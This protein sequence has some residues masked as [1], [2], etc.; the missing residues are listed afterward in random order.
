[1][2]RRLTWPLVLAQLLCAAAAWGDITSASLEIQGAGLRVETVSV[3]TGVDIPTT[4]QTSFGNR[5]NDDSPAVPGL[6]AV[7]DL[8]GPGIDVP[9]QLTATP[10]YRFH[11]PGLPRL[12]DYYLQNIRLMNGNEVI[13]PATPSLAKITVADLLQTSLA[14]RQLTPEQIRE[15]GI[16][17]DARNYD[18]YEYTFTFLVNGETVEVPFPVI[19]DPRTH[20]VTPVKEEK[21]YGLPPAQKNVQPPRWTP[22]EVIPFE[23]P[24]L[25][26]EGLPDPG[27]QP[28]E[29]NVRPNRP[30]IPAALVIPNSLAVLHQFFAVMLTVTNGA[31]TG[32]TARLED[33]G[34]TMKIK[35]PTALRTVKSTP[36]V[37]FGQA[38][39]VVDPNTGVT[40]LLAQGKGE[41]EWT[42]EGLK[43]GTHTVEVDIRATLREQGQEDVQLRATPSASVIIHDPRFNITFSHPDT[44]RRGLDYSTFAFI[45]NMSP[46]TQTIRVADALPQCGAELTVNVCRVAGGPPP[47]DMTIPAGEMRVVEYRLRAGETGQVFATAGSL[48]GDAITAAVQLHMGISASG[49]PLSPATLVLPYYAQFLHEDLV[50]DY[51][52]L[53]GLGYSLAT[54]PVNQT[55]ARFPRV[56]KTDVFY[57]ANDIARAG[58][59]VFIGHTSADT[60]RDA[61]N[62]LLL[63][64]LGNSIELR[65]WDE[66][67]R[68]EDAG[69]RAGAAVIR[70]LREA[71]IANQTSIG[72]AFD[73]FANDTS[74]RD[75]FVVALAH[76]P[77]G[78]TR[79]VSIALRGA[80]GR[81][82]S[83]ANEEA[84]GWTRDLA[85]ADVS[86]FDAFDRMGEL[87]V[88]GRWTEDLELIIT[89]ATGG[90]VQVELLFPGTTDGA[91]MR[92]HIE[93]NTAANTPLRVPLTRGATSLN[94]LL[95]NGGFA[96]TATASQLGPAALTILGA[97]QD[98]HLDKEG[99][100][101]S[102]LFS[103]PVTVAE[104]TDL[105]TRFAG[106]IDFNRDGIVFNDARPIFAAALQGDG[107]VANLSFDHVLSTNASYKITVSPFIDP[108]G[109]ASVPFSTP[110]VPK[111]DMDRPAGILY[112]RFLTGNN[113]PIAGAE[114]KFFTG[115]FVGCVGEGRTQIELGIACNPFAEAPQ[116]ARTRHD[117]SFL[118][119]YVPR[120]PVADPG[121]TGAYKAVGVTA[122]GKAT[123]VE[124]SVR[125]PGR[126]HIVNLQLL[127]RG[128]AE[129]TV[130]YDN[131]E[132]ARG[133]RVHVSSTM[134]NV[135][136][137]AITDNDGFFR[138]DDLA[139]GPITLGAQDDAG[140]V[141]FASGE[142]ATPGQVVVKE[143]VIFRKPFP[144][145]GTVYGKVTRSDN[146]APVFGARV[147]VYS[148]GYGFAEATTDS[149]GK[150][151]FAKVPSGFVT[152]LAAE[153]S[154]S[155]ENAAADFDLKADETKEMN[156]TISVTPNDMPLVRVTGRVLRENPLF[157]GDP[158]KY[159]RVPG[160]V[161]NLAILTTTAN[162]NG[163]FTF[164]GVPLIAGDQGSPKTIRAYDPSTK[165]I[166]TIGVP[167]LSETQP[168]DVT[169]FIPANSY[170]GG[171]IRVR[172]V[173]AAGVAVDGFRVIEPG[174]PP[175]N[176]TR[177]GAGLY[178]YRDAPI[179]HLVEVVAVDGPAAYG[180]QV[181]KG[182]IRL[183]FPGQT[184]TLI[185]RLPGQGTVRTKLRSDF[186]LIGDVALTFSVWDENEQTMMPFTITRS[187]SENGVAGFATFTAVP[188]LQQ[189]TV[190]SGHPVY[191]YA[192]QRGTLAYDGDVTIHTLQ[193]NKLATVRGT[194]YAID[195]ITPIANA[196]VRLTDGRRD[197]GIVHTQPDGTFVFH[198]VPA[199]VNFNVRAD[200]T[201]SGIY[202][203][204]IAF[205][206]TP[207][208]G[209]PAPEMSIILRRRGSVEGKVVYADYK[210]YDAENPANRVADDTPNDYSDNAPVPLAKLW[211]R[212][213]D[214]PERSF[215]SGA[216]P[217]TADVGGRFAVSNVF[218]GS[219]R[220]S[221]WSAENPDLRG[222]WTGLLNDEG[223]TLT[224]VYIAIGGGGTGSLQ[225]KVVDPNQQYLPIANAEVRLYR[226]GL[227]DLATTDDAGLV[228]F[229]Q[230]PVGNYGADAYSKSLGKS[231]AGTGFTIARDQLTEIRI[232]LEF[233]GKVDGRLT[234][235]MVTPAR[236]LPGV[237]VKLTASSFY[238]LATT[239][240]HGL[241]YF[242]G[243]REGSFNLEAKDTES[244]R[245]ASGQ[246]SVTPA[247]RRPF[248]ELELERTESLHVA[249]YLPNDTGGNSGT[250]A[251][252]FEVD[253]VQRCG[254]VCDYHRTLQGNPLVFPNLFLE[255][256]YNGTERYYVALKEIGGAGRTLS[257]D[258]V[259]PKG[260]AADPL[261]VVYPAFGGLEITVMQSGAL[262]QGARV[263]M[264]QGGE[265]RTVYTNA[266]GKAAGSGFQ[267]GNVSVQARSLDGDFTGSATVTIE[268]TSQ[269]A[270]RTIELG[271]YAGVSGFVEAEAGGASVGTRV[272][273]TFAGSTLEMLTDSNGGYLFQGI[274]TTAGG[275]PVS[276]SYVGPDGVTVG[277]RQSTS[278]NNDWSSRVRVLAPVKL[279]ATPPQLLTIAPADGSQNVSPDAPVTFVFSEQLDAAGLTGQNLQL[280]AADGSGQVT[281]TITSALQP[282]KTFAVTLRP[283]LQAGE[284]FPLKSNTLYR[285][286]VQAALGDLTGHRLPAPR[287]STFTT[288][289]YAEPRVVKL[290]PNNTA[291]LPAQ[292]TLQFHFN[293]PVDP[294]TPVFK[295]YKLSAAGAG[296]AVVA[297]KSGRA[298]VD[299]AGGLFLAF[300]PDQEIEPES[301]YRAV[302]TGV[303]DL[304]GNQ[305][306][307]QTYHYFSFDQRK[308][309]LRLI[310]PVPDGTSL[311]SGVQYTLNVDPRSDSLDGPVATDVA[312]VEYV[313]V[314]GATETFLT[315]VTAAPFAYRFSAPEAPEAGISYTIRA[316]ATDA[317]G[318]TGPP[319]TI[320]W[321]VK[322]NA[323][324]KN[325]GL[326][327]SS[328]SAYPGATITAD[329]TFEDEGILAPVQVVAR[330]PK[331][332]GTEYVQSKTAEAR[333]N[334]VGDPWPPVALTF[335]LPLTLTSGTTTEFTAT[336]TDV[337]GLSASATGSVSILADAIK[338][339]IVS[340]TPAP[341]KTYTL[342][343][344]YNVAAVVSD[345]ETGVSEVQFVIDGTQHRV[346]AASSTSGPG[347]GTRTFTS[348]QIT[349][350]AR[351]VDTRI[352]IIFRAIDYHGNI[353]TKTF[354]VVYIGVNDPTAPKGTW[355]C[356][357]DRAVIPASQTA[358]GLSLKVRAQDDVSVTAVK[359]RIPGLAEPV[360]ASRIGTSDDFE[361]L[362]TFDTPA[363]GSDFTIAAIISDAD[364]THTIELPIAIDVVAFDR[365]IEATEAVDA[366]TV[367]NYAGKSLLV[368][369]P[370][371]LVINVPLAVPNLAVTVGGRIET[372]GSTTARERKLDLTVTDRL[373]IDCTSTADVTAKGYLGGWGVNPDGTNTRSDS[374]IGRTT[375]NVTTGGAAKAGASHGGIATALSG[376]ATNAVYGSI[377]DPFELGSGG[378]GHPTDAN[379]AGGTGGGAL[380]LRTSN[381][382]D[383]VARIVVAG[384]IR[385]D[386]GSGRHG[387][388]GGSIRL[389]A[390]QIIFGPLAQV[391]ANGARGQNGCGNG[392]DQ[393]LGGS[394]GRIA[395]TA[396][397]RLELAAPFA[398][399]RAFG[400]AVGSG[401]SLLGAG[402]GT[403]YIRRPGQTEGEL[404]VAQSDSAA[405]VS[406]TRS[407]PL[408]NVAFD[409]ITLGPWALVRMDGTYSVG[410]VIDDP[411]K[412]VKDA[413]AIVVARNA[414]PAISGTTTPATGAQLIRNTPLDLLLD[415]TA[416]GGLVTA[417]SDFSAAPP[418]RVS[419]FGYQGSI[420]DHRVTW[421]VPPDAPLGPATLKVKVADRADRTLETTVA[422]FTVIDNLA[423]VI[424][425]YTAL[426]AS[427]YPGGTVT[428]SLSAH[429]DVSVTKI[430]ATA[431]IGASA[432][433][434]Q[435]R[436]PNAK[437]VTNET[438]TFTIPVDTPGGTPMTVEASVEDAFPG[439]V[440][441]KQTANITILSDTVGPQVTI[442][443]PAEAHVFDE[444]VQTF[445]INVTATDGEV[446]VRTVTARVG[447]GSVVTLTGNAAA[448]TWTGTLGIP[449]VDGEE[450]VPFT[451]TV[452]ATDYAG[453]ATP[454]TGTIRV[455]PTNDPN[456]PAVSWKCGRVTRVAAGVPVK[457]RVEAI[458]AN[459]Q[460]PVQ[461]VEF[462]IDSN[463]PLVATSIGSNLY[464]AT[465][466]VPAGAATYSVRA[467]GT[468][469]GGAERSFTHT[470]T[471]V[472]ADHVFSASTTIAAAD[473]SY[474]NEVIAVTAGTLTIAGAHT[475]ADLFVLGTA[476][477]THPAGDASL[478]ITTG[479]LFIACDASFDVTSRGYGSGGTYP[480]ATAAAS[481]AG[482]SHIGLGNAHEGGASPGT[483]Y[484]SVYRPQELG[485]GA[486]GSVGGG[487]VAVVAENVT[488]DGAVRANGGNTNNAG[489][490]AGGSVWIRT[491][492]I[493]G[494]GTIDA[495]GGST[496]DCCGG[497]Y[498][499]GGGGAISIEYTDA[500]S[501][502]PTLRARTSSAP[503]PG[504]AGTIWVKGPAATWGRLTIDNGGTGNAVTTLPSLGN[505]LAQAGSA[506]ATLVTD[507]ASDVPQYFVGHFVEIE[508]KGTYRVLSAG[509]KTLTLEAPAN[510]AP[511][512]KWQGVYL[513]D[514]LTVANNARLSSVDPIR[515][516]TLEA[517]GNG[518]EFLTGIDAGVVTVRGNAS[519]STVKANELVVETGGVLRSRGGNGLAIDAG[520]LTVRGTIDVTGQ[521]FAASTTYGGATAPGSGSGA[522]HMGL[523]GVHNNPAATSF[524]SIYRPQEAGGGANGSIGG[525]VVKIDADTVTV[526]GAIRANAN[527]TDNAG[528]GAGGSI[529]IQA[530]RISG[531]GTIE[532]NGGSTSD[533]CGGRYGGG[534]G[535]AIAIEYTDPASALPVLRA[536]GISAPK[537]GGAGTVYVKGP[538]STFGTLTIDNAG[539]IGAPTDLP[540]L[541]N[542]TAQTGTSGTTLVTD[543]AANIPTYFIG[544]WV[545]I[546]GKGSWRITAI[547]AKTAT[548]ES[549]ADLAPG[550]KWQGVYR[551]D[552]LILNTNNTF[553]SIDPIRLPSG[554]VLTLNGPT[555][556]GQYLNV[557]QPV[558]TE[559]VVVNG[560]VAAS[561]IT[562]TNMTVSAGATLVPYNSSLVTLDVKNLTVASGGSIDVTGRGHGPF[563]TYSGATA[564]GS[565]SGAAHMGAGG[566]H[567]LPT[568]T[569][570]GS[571]YQPAEAGGGG[572]GSAGGGV[573]KITSENVT[574]DGF[575][576]ANGANTDNA[577]SGAGGSIWI[578]TAKIAG[579]GT[580]EANGGA[581]SDC[582][583]GRY[584]GGGG[585]A[586]AIEYTDAASTLPTLRALAV[587]A[588]KPGGAG[589]VFVRGA[590][591]TFGTLT[592]DNANRGGAPTILP[593]LGSGIAQAGSA[594]TTLVTDRAINI[595]AYFAG[596]W[597]EIEGKGTW[598]IT[599]VDAKT[600]TLE[601]GANVAAGDKW[602]GVYR[603][604]NVF[605]KATNTFTTVDPIRLPAGANLTLEGPANAGVW[606]TLTEALT[607]ERV[608][609]KGNVS[610][611]NI[612]ADHL[613][614]SPSAVLA[615]Y[616]GSTITLDVKNLTVAA[617]GAIDVTGRGHG[618]N[619]TYAGATAPGAGSGGSHM[620]VGG[621]R[622]NP[623][624]TT[625][626]SVYQ[627]N[628]PGGGAGN[629]S[630]GGGVVKIT[631]EN[632]T[633]DGFVRANG[634]NIA[635][636]G[637][638]AG[639]SIWIRTAKI[640]G[641]GTIEAN[642]GSVSECCGQGYGSG[643]GGAVAIEYTDATSTLPTLRAMAASGPRTG[644]AGTVF[645]KRASSTYGEL[646][647]DN[648]NKNGWPTTL[649]SLGSGIAQAGTAGTALVTD[650]ASNIPAYFIGHW[651][652]IEGKGTWRIT[653]VNAKTATLEAGADVA[654]GDK[655]QGVYRFDNVFLKA[656][657]TFTS[658][659]P[660][661][662][663]AGTDMVLEGPTNA[664]LA[665]MLTEGLA[666]ERVTVKGNVA[667]ANVKADHL[668]VATGGVLVPYNSSLITLDVKNLAVAA[669][670]AID[671]TGRGHGAGGTYSGA[672]GPG[673]G[674]GGAHM[675]VGGVRNAPTATTFGSIYQPN[676]SGG[677]A[678]NGSAGGGVVK[679][680]SES[681]TVDGFVRANGVNIA[682]D[683]SGAGGSIWIRTAK[684]A[685]A[686]TIEANSGSVSECCGQGYGTGGGGAVAIEY[687]DA[688]STLPMLRA[689]A[690]SG[691]RIGGAGTVYVKGA[692]STYGELT[693]DNGNKSG[694]PTI[695]PSLGSGTAQAGSSGTTLVTDRAANIPAYF[696]GHWVEIEG[697]G[698][699]RI[700]AVNAK[701]AT[702]EAGANVAAGDRW[703]GVYRFDNVF[704][705]GINTFTTLDPIRLPAGANLTLDGPTGAGQWLVLT[706]AL[707]TERV[708]IK[709][710][711]IVPR[712]EG[713]HLTVNAAAVLYSP[714]LT[715][716]VKNITVAATGAIDATS[717]GFGG[718]ATYAGATLP[719]SGTGGAH[720]GLGGI[721][722]N[723][724]GTTFGSI[725]QPNE[726]G[727][728]GT[729]SAGG[730]VI[731]ITAETL[732]VDGA[733]R[734]NSYNVSN[735]SSGAGG[736][737]L[738]RTARIA[739]TGTIEASS[740]TVSECCGQGYGSGGG[741]AIAVDYTDATS[742][743]PTLR[744]IGANAPRIGGAG[745]VFVKHPSSTHGDL[746]VDNGGRTGHNVT[747]FPSLGNG[748]ALAGSSGTTLV[749]DRAASIPS[750][751]IGH[752]VEIEG[753][754]TWRITAV[755]AKTA[756]LE[757]GANVAAGDRWQGVYRVDTLRLRTT[758]V[759]SGDPIRYGTLDSVSSTLVVNSGAPQFP[760]A[761]RPQIVISGDVVSGPAGAVTD[762]DT[763]I[764]VTTTNTRTQQSYTVNAAANGAF[765]IPVGGI[766]G[767]TFTIHATDSHT[768]PMT[769]AA[770]PVNGAF[771]ETNSIVSF[772]IDPPTVSGGTT[773]Y[774]S[775]RLAMPARA[776]GVT[777]SLANANSA[778]TVP[779]T[780]VIPYGSTTAQFAIAT[781]S[782]GVHTSGA[783]T[784]SLANA[785]SAMLTVA[786]TS[787]TL[788][789]LTLSSATI[790][791]GTSVDATVTLGGAAPPGGATVMLAADSP[792]VTL[793]SS[794][795]VA[796]G[797]T[798]LTFSVAT[799]RVAST[800]TASLS[801]T[802]GATR[803]ASLAL[804]A[805]AAM[806]SAAAPAPPALAATWVDDAAPAGAAVTGDAVFDN[807]QVATGSLALH[808]AANAATRSWSFT[809]AA[810]LAVAANDNLVLYALVNPC[811][812]PRQ[813]LVS[814]S[815]GTT[816]WRAS[817]G[818][819]RIAPLATNVIGATPAGGVWTRLE[820]P[821]RIIG[822]P[823]TSLTRLTVSVDRGELW[824]DSIGKTSCALAKQPAPQFLAGETVWFD[825]TLPAGAI[826][827]S[828]FN[829]STAQAASGSTSDLLTGTGRQEHAFHN[830]TDAL[831]MTMDDM[832]V[833]YALVDPCNPP[834]QIMIRFHDGTEWYR[835]AYWGENLI[836]TGYRHFTQQSPTGV[837]YNSVTQRRMGPMPE[838]GRWVRLE[839]P[840]S[841]MLMSGTTI[842]GISFNTY[843]GQAWIDRVA[844]VSR[845]N[846]ALGKTAS[847]ISTYQNLP[848]Y[849]AA[850]AVDGDVMNLTHTN[851]HA[852]AWLEIDLGAVQPIETI[853]VWNY[854]AC[855]MERMQAFYVLVSEEPFAS[856]NLTTARN[857]SGVSSYYHQHNGWRPS[858]FEIGRRGRYVR[859]QLS[860]N[861]YLHASEVQVWAPVSPMAVN[862]AG[863]RPATQSSTHSN[864]FASKA[865]NGSSIGFTWSHTTLEAGAWWQADLGSIQWISTVD[866]DNTIPGVPQ[867]LADFYLYV[868]D[869]P[870]ASNTVAGTLAQ[871]GVGVYYRGAWKTAH[872]YAVNRT[873]RYVR[874]QLTG[875]NYLNPTEV[876]VLSPLLSLPALA[877]GPPIE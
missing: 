312:S 652:E 85:F 848:A 4:I 433:T 876:K 696:I 314:D 101:V 397:E 586:V 67:R 323:A 518:L 173:S 30:R 228:R 510:V 659:D 370:G 250:L 393:C 334:S 734:S 496:N 709:G 626:G 27:Q 809:G 574:V 16:I 633:V 315:T 797:S 698:T 493:S 856:T 237:A 869:L 192:E 750:Y 114:I 783:I 322:P 572:N 145:T 335:N 481:G 617:T 627:P 132:I 57:R 229:D 811:N 267:L 671:V 439:R 758:T 461:K 373:Y 11:I 90:P 130:K 801:G 697:K 404:Y 833:V 570:F 32:S 18:V 6:L 365:V 337:R 356:P 209:G 669:T 406:Y 456:A 806:P 328:T 394:G 507:R 280:I 748:T 405:A 82:A 785:K 180:E 117:G 707:V 278:I 562:A 63:D 343:A 242:E 779:S 124:G 220:A 823:A 188:G 749:T 726:P 390:R 424:D 363:A 169:V 724:S 204:G 743:L 146:G 306:A 810:P 561:S 347:A 581:T 805:C 412:I 224:G 725:R 375:G 674:T 504:A 358:Y 495:N 248:V 176:L 290:V 385:A 657:N 733:I 782:V 31:P 24:D 840:V 78:A 327:L 484:G 158:T 741:G 98:L 653:A 500:T 2:I 477:V 284:R 751:F 864:E 686:G 499:G 516:A 415:L 730:G 97:R 79:P 625:F 291:P 613:T 813:I 102:L 688:T 670:G 736:S 673:N 523:G 203:T 472:V 367:Q 15:R 850:S 792:L 445:A 420:D 803:S 700:T 392:A 531:T 329:V 654:A 95:P 311:V 675:G 623:T 502:L 634:V 601:A 215:G 185:L 555:A 265:R 527:N 331:T 455:R 597:V 64:L 86:R 128:S 579:G 735:N 372:L 45:T 391:S 761:L 42:L 233:V 186:D 139:V 279:D 862:F 621:V 573:V 680:T 483:T 238:A 451:I 126:V 744:A 611:A 210:V 718:G 8:S 35:V 303:R 822:M 619:G 141:T 541:G 286:V 766:S 84:G 318:N 444:A 512:D 485:A 662:L 656:T 571:V 449:P 839:I 564:P 830:A 525:G 348:P 251:G 544:H 350:T 559:S 234:D 804:T 647:V 226:G 867:R 198:D 304:Q 503:R 134:F 787:A 89:S 704:L 319:S 5:T 459:A 589:T 720:I 537:P 553:T 196:A 770:I 771:A 798:Q 677:G 14:V 694:W 566:T 137:D 606:L 19:I 361:V 844:K 256:R 164:D 452:T 828:A 515:T 778:A 396:D 120:D 849:A 550:D 216:D 599:A 161:V 609:V 530:G 796:E 470:V 466:N 340:T 629:G 678:G 416:A 775:L 302:F 447:E 118:F 494:L 620:G 488:L 763:P 46:Q 182:T 260:T 354:D 636:D 244:N 834:R 664:G 127:G 791:G 23:F 380:S 281:C 585:G 854:G 56:I 838:G 877:K 273:A 684:I 463:P 48:D 681:V 400:G 443:A 592:V 649:P 430:S 480:G 738:I 418:L 538:A 548:L 194:V 75:P 177:I 3:T 377:T 395:L 70:E 223:Q 870:F 172:V 262:V 383:A 219:L 767:D 165:R 853:D 339:V 754:G 80:S 71:L 568:S 307:E 131:G 55:T 788:A 25:S 747:D 268:R 604:D 565:G 254:N 863:G 486:N 491:A 742:T 264:S 471:S 818:E 473:A 558:V 187:T 441:T 179:G 60:K 283:N 371:R 468:S 427:L 832:I 294:A 702:L 668:T 769:S 831:T 875:T 364:E 663:P 837:Q 119:E 178:E 275:T 376:G 362:A 615:P 351:N 116:Y 225:V 644:G 622:N 297:E 109:G 781:S 309:Y 582:C 17:V 54:A 511:G 252:P 28:R 202:R 324:P 435:S 287:G 660:I 772:T 93:V 556:A 40:V 655:W 191:G 458:A 594:G 526:I 115:H 616:N 554:A 682:N 92:A 276:L 440:A 860:G 618:A 355:L 255:N 195:G 271:A 542:G 740:G 651:V 88:A 386:A 587:S 155:R 245:W 508:G 714:V 163:E 524:G 47:A 517:N 193:L 320:T 230:L 181:G 650:R 522:A 614:V 65:E 96:S 425:T 814:F 489:S 509:A 817:W 94:V 174:Y 643:G 871:D 384:S 789:T 144:G 83:V 712:I 852:E 208:I 583:G 298:Y 38:V 34:A 689:M 243:I 469:S 641:T 349:A 136:R 539:R 658:A 368:R 437:T 157:P 872:T 154:I 577:G 498:G 584:G 213:L 142:I 41:A 460:N 53:L 552:N 21:D 762:S 73:E 140:N 326:A 259:F 474:D 624:A 683:G 10:G 352:P 873:G 540:S 482:G 719:G 332:D 112:G 610:I 325:V 183:D 13:Q 757:A 590:G 170:G 402:A 588:P 39:P 398:Q 716:D 695:L 274:P 239:D 175:H 760:A 596:H 479:T 851:S 563:G 199:A 338:P 665:L 731:T 569:T 419:P 593:S 235:P 551:L 434:A 591:A 269:T 723:P 560:N 868:S 408:G 336:V 91:T 442:N 227:F 600:A 638:G 859:L 270:T 687:T 310:S 81:T 246:G 598:R 411:A 534:G 842:R 111:I 103:R 729:G 431:Q 646:T 100:K 125:L 776:G 462:F 66:L 829:P 301:Y 205:G 476:S 464:E 519:A 727:G 189:Y 631:S 76:G 438:F 7:G 240:T 699:W 861:N 74:H 710:N 784:A 317:S 528:S 403:I 645:V 635:N 167:T 20:V 104:G 453:N 630:A 253:V 272:L 661:R 667:I 44:V 409:K 546:A 43:P 436:T 366:D 547:D 448:T 802:Y 9:I 151:E 446:K 122:E 845:V 184:A 292:V 603:F 295:F 450:V 819:S 825:D 639:G 715:L 407:T 277:A 535:G 685:G 421:T 150:F 299:P 344:K 428:A 632:V 49:I 22:P 759:Q 777:V 628:E 261:K 200:V 717:G 51:L 865:V 342:N 514:G 166:G 308:P 501:T 701:T 786:P 580:I 637:S 129:G 12:G 36:S 666:T 795:T 536:L 752:W 711:V 432:P 399:V 382:A 374:A 401:G 413:T 768:L 218:T 820:V 152:L 549:G 162:D 841:G 755:N 143:L 288:S 467:A 713:D 529:W 106:A 99:H 1:M 241:F 201:Q 799:T 846:L 753:K 640:A 160:A 866:V 672:G 457:L 410:G 207:D 706:E 217:L 765:S 282:D 212:E 506:G 745:T 835:S 426:P 756:T 794:V 52:E 513:V 148:Q 874:L 62:N 521:G 153:W 739:G 732:T 388:A 816:D 68:S 602:Q 341:E 857:Q 135:G 296:G 113:T 692:S 59:R 843:D 258:G 305:L 691:P 58:Q 61:L 357:I 774:G 346:F 50:G 575:I 490:G 77:S 429:D 378:A 858:T 369:G 285:I 159:E 206:R 557:T 505:G 676:E 793:P 222:N 300:A 608:T 497:R 257:A 746:T 87:A 595:P 147:G 705:K 492:R 387:G 105:L 211:L 171:T 236:E 168:N 321:T 123:A 465:W 520:N 612:E 316:K 360:A 607:T 72:G 414:I 33:I 133:V 576:R 214:F 389:N 107:R 333:R 29:R 545:E 808:F 533:C 266:A 121:L 721:R 703:Q 642:S 821:A 605:L 773:A 648:A 289:D 826:V 487:L 423:P 108:L 330:G 567:N 417:E 679:I 26:G 722:N 728:G 110:V 836:D 812:P 764:K 359:F 221:A 345:A 232:D 478:R 149:D 690:A 790:E 800:T 379:N 532:A 422:T 454:K 37:A 815:D 197:A 708:T 293:E 693:V 855:C 231:G 847:Q 263:E 737:V 313:K 247:N 138:V 353:T 824:L 578:R 807:T 156:L 381:T 543:R 249:V 475:F 780:I 827:S 190:A 69:R